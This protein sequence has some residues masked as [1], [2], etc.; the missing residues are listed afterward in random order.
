[1]RDLVSAVGWTAL[2]FMLLAVATLALTRYPPSPPLRAE[3][4]LPHADK[5]GF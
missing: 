2:A 3:D 5:P 4:K 1:V